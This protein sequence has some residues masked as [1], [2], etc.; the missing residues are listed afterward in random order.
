MGSLGGS[1][2]DGCD[3]SV[4]DG[5]LN[6]IDDPYMRFTVARTAGTLVAGDSCRINAGYMR[7]ICRARSWGSMQYAK[8]YGTRSTTA[9]RYLQGIRARQGMRARPVGDSHGWNR[10]SPSCQLTPSGLPTVRDG[11][12]CRSLVT[13]DDIRTD[14]GSIHVMY[15]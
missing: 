14:E 10:K 5:T 13:F 15:M 7:H 9:G 2:W 1:I 8:Q 3:S 11:G 4:P 6:A 12:L